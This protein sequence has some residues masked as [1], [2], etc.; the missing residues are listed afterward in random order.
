MG[1]V[2]IKVE[3]MHCAGCVKRAEGALKKVKGLKDIE[4]SL[5]NKTITCNFKKQIDGNEIVS[6]LAEVGFEASVSINQ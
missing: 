5:E 6:A 4:T 3:G 1:K 2:T